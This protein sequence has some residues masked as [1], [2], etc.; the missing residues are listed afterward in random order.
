MGGTFAESYWGPNLLFWV[1]A[2]LLGLIPAKI[3]AGKGRSF[4]AWWIYGTLIFIVAL[5]HALF[6][7]P[8]RQEGS[9]P[10]KTQ[11]ASRKCPFCGKPVAVDSNFCPHCGKNLTNITKPIDFG[12]HEGQE[13]PP[14]QQNQQEDQQ[15]SLT[16]TIET[17][18]T[19]SNEAQPPHAKEQATPY[20]TEQDRAKTTT[21]QAEKKS[22]SLI[23][24]AGVVFG[25]SCLFLPYLALLFFVPVTLACGAISIYKGEKKMGA[26]IIVLAIIGLIWMFHVSSKI[27][28]MLNF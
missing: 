19:Q 22:P 12:L 6:L 18:E 23:A 4:V 14:N 8:I 16:T 15:A 9:S 25:V 27:T 20:P 28:A 17:I 1:I 2:I 3:A 5:P 10:P 11:E 7:K 26:L 24:I 13:V 21:S